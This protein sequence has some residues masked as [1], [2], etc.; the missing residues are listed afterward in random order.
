VQ[1]RSDITITPLGVAM[2][3][4]FSVTT[5]EM[6]LVDEDAFH[7]LGGDELHFTHL[8]GRSCCLTA[9]GSADAV[10]AIAL[11]IRCHHTAAT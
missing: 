8:D 1:K 6:W 5:D 2:T 10:R 9:T 11:G 7:A 4:E 3:S